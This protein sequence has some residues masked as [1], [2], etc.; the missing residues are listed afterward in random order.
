[1][2]E[3]HVVVKEEEQYTGG[4]GYKGPILRELGFP[5]GP[6]ILG[7][8]KLFVRQAQSVNSKARFKIVEYKAE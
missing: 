7:V 1:M 6:Y 4:V 5:E 8:A 3:T 2:L